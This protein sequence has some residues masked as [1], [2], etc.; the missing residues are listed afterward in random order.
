MLFDHL[1]LAYLGAFSRGF[2]Q[3]KALVDK[4][5]EQGIT[6]HHFFQHRDVDP[7]PETQMAGTHPEDV[8]C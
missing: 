4:R 2:Y 5:G 1:N 3:V 6:D 8:C 7:R